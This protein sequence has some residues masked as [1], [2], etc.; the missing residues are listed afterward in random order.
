MA[1]FVKW[2]KEKLN[3]KLTHHQR[4]VGSIPTGPTCERPESFLLSGPFFFTRSQAALFP[5]VYVGRGIGPRR[6][7]G[8]GAFCRLPLSLQTTGVP[9][10]WPRYLQP[11]GARHQ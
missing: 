4:V 6:Q 1:Y 9:A 7:R 3:K 5:G 10:H 11:D 2:S 8:T